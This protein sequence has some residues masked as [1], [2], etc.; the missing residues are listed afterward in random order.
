MDSAQNELLKASTELQELLRAQIHS[1]SLAVPRE[2]PTHL[3]IIL[4][5]DPMAHRILGLEF[6]TAKGIAGWVYREQQPFLKNP[7]DQPPEHFEAIDMFA[8]TNTGEGAILT[9][10]LVLAGRCRGVIQFIKS[11]GGRF[12]ETDLLLASPYLP[13]LAQLLVTVDETEDADSAT[14]IS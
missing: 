2:D 7:G 1:I 5:T 11:E 4:S 10:P 14:R 3:R 6:P 9:F 8:G 12:E 13:D